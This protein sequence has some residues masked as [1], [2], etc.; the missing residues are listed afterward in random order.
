MQAFRAFR[1]Q[2]L[3]A[4]DV[5]NMLFLFGIGDGTAAIGERRRD[6]EAEIVRKVKKGWREI[7]DGLERKS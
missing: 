6:V 2:V 4:E 7:R 5:E 1:K 3:S